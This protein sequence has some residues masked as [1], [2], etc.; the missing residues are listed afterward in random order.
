[1]RNRVFIE[2]GKLLHPAPVVVVVAGREKPNPST[3]IY[4]A[5]VN[6]NPPYIFVGIKEKRFTYK[7]IEKDREFTVNVVS[8]EMLKGA[9]I[10]GSF[11]GNQKDKSEICGFKFRKAKRVN[12]FY[13]DDSPVVYEVKLLE[14]I[15]LRDHILLVGEVLATSVREDLISEDKFLFEKAGFVCGCYKTLSYYS[16][17]EFIKHWGF[18]LKEG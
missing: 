15:K 5:Q 1:M 4:F 7:L 2:T 13:I 8:K 12:T 6:D 10:S 17:G 18:S 3:Y 11:T 16:L 9:D 14:E